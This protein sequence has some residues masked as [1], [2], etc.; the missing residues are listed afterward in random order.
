MLVFIFIEPESRSGRTLTQLLF[1]HA[2]IVAL[3][4]QIGSMLAP[5]AG[6]LNNPPDRAAMLAFGQQVIDRLEPV[7][8]ARDADPRIRQILDYAAAHLDGPLSLQE[9]AKGIYLSPSRLRHLFVEQTGL[10]FKTYLLWLRLVRAL[11]IYS[12]GQSLTDAAHFAGFSDSAH[13]SRIFR[14]TFGLPASTLTRI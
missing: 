10:P 11:E 5:L 8:P 4:P 2:E 6:T 9:A 14:R 12:D 3:E 13:L 7:I 1:R